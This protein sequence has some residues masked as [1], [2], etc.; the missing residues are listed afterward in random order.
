L[1]ILSKYKISNLSIGCLIAKYIPVQQESLVG[2]KFDKFSPK[3]IW[4]RKI[5][6]MAL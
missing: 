4:Q 1:A 3:K 2:G 5:W 6:Q